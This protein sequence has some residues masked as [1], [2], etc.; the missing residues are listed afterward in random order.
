MLPIYLVN[1]FFTTLLIG[2]RFVDPRK[3]NFD[4]NNNAILNKYH[5]EPLDYTIQFMLF[6]LAPIPIIL[7][8]LKTR[9]SSKH[10]KNKILLL[11]YTGLIGASGVIETIKRLVGELRPDFI[12]R[13]QPDINNNCTGNQ[14]TVLRGRMSFPSGH[15]SFALYIAVEFGIICHY[16][17]I[18][19]KISFTIVSVF[20]A[21]AVYIGWSRVLWNRHFWHD[22]ICGMVIAFSMALFMHFLANVTRKPKRKA[23]S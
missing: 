14:R 3:V 20:L 5:K 6:S 21:V 11:L 8:L 17:N 23:R 13:C 10:T 12:S 2:T 15:S 7:W 9:D 22:V 1:A 18:P 16:L 19:K 4:P